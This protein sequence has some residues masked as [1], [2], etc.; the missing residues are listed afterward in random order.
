M[1]AELGPSRQRGGL[2]EAPGLRRG[3]DPSLAL[4]MT[5][6]GRLDDPSVSAER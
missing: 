4:R 1:N 6:R 2:E 5:S 3:R